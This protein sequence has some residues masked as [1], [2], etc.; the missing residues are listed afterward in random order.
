MKSLH[1]GIKTSYRLEDVKPLELTLDFSIPKKAEPGAGEPEPEEAVEE[2]REEIEQREASGILSQAR[3]QAKEILRQAE[4]DAAELKK[5]A[6]KEGYLAGFKCGREEGKKQAE[7]EGTQA[8]NEKI[9]AVEQDVTRFLADSTR[10]K[11]EL[12]DQYLEDLKD[13][14]VAVAQKVI[15]VSMKSNGDVIKRM[16]MSATDTVKKSQWAKIYIAKADARFLAQGD[17]IFLKNLSRISDNVKIVPV[18]NGEAGTCIVELPDEII[19]ASV[20]SQMDNIR[21]I[22]HHY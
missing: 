21:S 17:A 3:H 9:Q 8:W 4:Q 6:E 12:L 19:D 18:E 5:Q 22:I 13:I 10:E 2:S 20:G 15:N 16:I 14:A 7:A 1:K 11:E